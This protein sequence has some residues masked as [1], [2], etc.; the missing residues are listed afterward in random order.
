VAD[1]PDDRAWFE[2]AV[3]QLLPEL[4]GT[5]RRLARNREDAEDLVAEAIT[6]AWLRRA[7]LREPERFAGW[8]IRILTNLFLSQCR[9]EASHPHE[10]LDPG[11]EESFSLFER[12]HQPFLL[13]WGTPEQDFLDRLLEED[14]VRAIEALPEPFRIVVTLSDVQGFS[15]G[16][17]AQA[18]AVPIGTIRSRL[19][20]GRALLQRALWEHACDAGLRGTAMERRTG[21]HE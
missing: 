18:L 10:T 17:I 16:E 2:Q 7:T 6:R 13:W 14:L 9:S 15:Y 21:L 12:L 1:S 4:V 20:R 19:A 5:A 3:L 11:L 8:M